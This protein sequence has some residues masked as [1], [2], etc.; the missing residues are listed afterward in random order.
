MEM[1]LKEICAAV[2]GRLLVPAMPDRRVNCLS[3][4]SRVISATDFFVP[5]AGTRTDGHKFIAQAAQNGAIGCFS[6]A[7]RTISYPEGMTVIGVP[8]PLAALQQLAAVY[9]QKFELPVVAVTGSVGKT[10]TKE[11]IAAT[12]SVSLKTL[13]TEGNLNNHLGVPLMLSRLDSSHQAAVL[14]M[15]MSGF[16][17]IELLARLA[18]PSVAVITNIGE[19]HLEAVGSRQGIAKAKC[20]LLP[21]VSPNGTVVANADESLLVPYLEQVD[22]QVITFGFSAGAA[23]RCVAI[24]KDKGRLSVKVE[25]TGYA[26]LTL[27]SPLPGRHNIYNLLAALAVGRLLGLTDEEFNAGLARISISG[28]RL[29]KVQTPSGI[30]VL[31]DAYNASPTSMAAAI[32]VLSEQAGD[33]AKIAVLGDMLELGGFEEEGHRKI[34]NLVAA[35]ALDALIV[36]GGRAQI[37][38][39]AAIAAGYP[40]ER[41]FRPVSHSAAAN[42]LVQLAGSGDWAL[43]K[44]SRGMRMEDV[45]AELLEGEK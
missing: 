30:N 26:P 14:E 38:A 39:D 7:E 36:L 45:L 6:S 27:F 10:T 33:A 24:G 28:M 37:I 20:E 23:V 22:C 4:D 9:R 34:G 12:L 42:L 31:N 41:V 17:E 3:I 25:Q 29:E 13:K 18:R 32:D 44:G 21:Y 43:L 5:L 15:G 11:L 16:G 2:D 35:H 1:I 19:S 40:R 8:S